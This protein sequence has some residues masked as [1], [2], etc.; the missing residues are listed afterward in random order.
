MDVTT[1]ID[2]N[3]LNYV[4]IG[5]DIGGSMV[6]I[7]SCI[8]IDLPKHMDI[9]KQKC[10]DYD[11]LM[12]KL[13]NTELEQFYQF[14]KK[15]K[16]G[17]NSDFIVNITG[18]GAYKWEKSITKGLEI[19]YRKIDEMESLIKGFCFAIENFDNEVFTYSW[20]DKCID[21]YNN[22]KKLDQYFPCFVV[23][24]GSG[25]SILKVD[26]PTEYSRVSGTSLGGATF[27][28]LC[29]LLTGITNFEEIC[30]LSDRGKNKNLDLLVGDIYGGD[31]NKHKLESY[32]IASN[33]GKVGAGLNDDNPTNED[34]IKSLIYM[35]SDNI[36][37]ITYLNIKNEGIQNVFFTG[38]FTLL[39][40]CLWKK[41]SYGIEFWSD[42]KME[43]RFLTHS[44]YLS[45]LG[46]LFL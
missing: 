1:D 21:C 43:A 24:I 27:L 31:Y 18:G 45:A 23:N 28:G 36:A 3:N 35:F 41:L 46:S 32:M 37:Q 42:A 44:G 26:S 30:A 10:D 14:L 4:N 13:P 22:E 17:K 8:D 16:V 25:I 29:K 40:P 5:V 15:K 7:V 6:K 2:I 12:V 34:I 11:I 20:R 19:Q 39:G 33:F 38:N 9:I